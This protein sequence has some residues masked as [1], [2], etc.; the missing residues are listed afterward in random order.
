[1]TNLSRKDLFNRLKRACNEL[2]VNFNPEKY[3]NL[4]NK[5]LMKIIITMEDEVD[6]LEENRYENF[7]KSL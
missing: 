2:E 1:M 3:F 5:E 6:N 7:S 4:S